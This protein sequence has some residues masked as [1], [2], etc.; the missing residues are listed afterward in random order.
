MYPYSQSFTDNTA[1]LT[2]Y[3]SH[4]FTIYQDLATVVSKHQYTKDFM[5]GMQ[6]PSHMAQP[7]KKDL[8]QLPTQVITPQ[9]AI[10][11]FRAINQCKGDSPSALVGY[12]GK[13]YVTWF[14]NQSDTQSTFLSIFATG[15]FANALSAM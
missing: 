13:V 5:I 11:A 3:S 8:H 15:R 10:M 9:E 7:K 2:I 1:T 4:V 12:H 6:E 14:T